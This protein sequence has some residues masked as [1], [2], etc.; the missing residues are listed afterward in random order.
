M[1]LEES[2]ITKIGPS[3]ARFKRVKSKTS[4][5]KQGTEC[6]GSLEHGP[7]DRH[8][9]GNAIPLGD[10]LLVRSSFA[11]GSSHGGRVLLNYSLA[12]EFRRDFR[13]FDV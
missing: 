9:R 3:V 5:R 4:R 8:M 6:D 12:V 7:N 10:C 13:D 1:L 11:D 2:F